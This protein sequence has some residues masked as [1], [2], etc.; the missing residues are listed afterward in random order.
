STHRPARKSDACFVGNV[1][2]GS[3]M[4]VVK[5]GAAGLLALQRD[6][7]TRRIGE[8]DVEPPIAVVVQQR[9]TAAHRFDNVTLLRAGEMRKVDSSGDS[10]VHKSW[11]RGGGR[12]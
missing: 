4:V 3:V 5:Q 9:D 8:V 11:R 12:G 7:H 1:S 6:R 10:D 2:E